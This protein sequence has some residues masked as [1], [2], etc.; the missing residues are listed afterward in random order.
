MSISEQVKELRIAEETFRQIGKKGIARFL[1][2]AADTIE[3]LSQKLAL[4]TPKRPL[5]YEEYED[6]DEGICPICGEPVCHVYSYCPG[7]GQRLKWGSSTEESEEANMER[8]AEDCRGWIYCGDGK[9]LPEEH[10]SMFAKFKE[11]EKWNN[12]MFEKISD[13]VNVTVEFDDGARKTKTLHTIDG[14]WNG[15]NR[16]VK[17]KVIAWQPLPE[18]YSP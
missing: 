7:C 6:Y 4:A 9:N 16:G 17:F 14:K 3:A 18:S 5:K 11:T 15:G 2:E 8:L 13:D 1:Q 10:D 12:S